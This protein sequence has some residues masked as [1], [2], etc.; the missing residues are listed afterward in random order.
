[1]GGVRAVVGKR[2]NRKADKQRAVERERR[3][4]LSGEGQPD[5]SA[6]DAHRLKR[7]C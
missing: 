2:G 4:R 1:M 5:L 6:H 7:A 3:R